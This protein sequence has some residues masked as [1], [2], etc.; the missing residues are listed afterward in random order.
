VALTGGYDFCIELGIEVVRE[1][2]HLAFKQEDR[3]P[4]NFGPFERTLTAPGGAPLTALVRVRVYDEE[5]RPADLRFTDVETLTFTFPIDIDIEL[6]D[7]PAPDL[8]HLLIP[9][10]IEVPGKLRRLPASEA[11]GEYALGVDFGEITAGD[12]VIT[13][14]APLPA[15]DGA[16]LTSAIHDAYERGTFPHQQS[17]GGFTLTAYDGSRDTSLSPPNESGAEIGA[18][19]GAGD[20]V[21]VT[22]PIHVGGEQ[23]GY[24]LSSYG[25][26]R[27]FR[28]LERS[29]DAVVLHM[30]QV[31]APGDAAHATQVTL[32]EVPGVDASVFEAA[33]HQAYLDGVIV[34]QTTMGGTL[35]LYDGTADPALVPAHPSAAEI[36]AELEVESGTTY[37][38]IQIPCHAEQSGF[39]SFGVLHIHRVVTTTP[40][41]VSVDF[42][43]APA[44][45]GRETRFEMEIGFLD[46]ILNAYTGGI[47]LAMNAIGVQSGPNPS[48]AIV[49]A[50]AS[51]FDAFSASMGDIV[52]AAPSDARFD[53]L[54][55]DE[56]AT[57]FATLS[58]PV[59]T[60]DPGENDVELSDPVGK[61]LV[62]DEILAIQMNPT[63][64]EPDAVPDNF[65]GSERLAL[66]VGLQELQRQ[67][68][69]HIAETFPD[70]ATEGRDRIE[71]ITNRTVWLTSLSVTPGS[72]QFNVSG[73]ATVEVCCWKDPDIDF[74]GPVYLN[75]TSSTEEGCMLDIQGEAGEFDTNQSSCDIVLE[76]F[77]PVVGWIVGIVIAVMIDSVGGGIAE[78]IAEEQEEV[79]S[80]L[81]PVIFGIAQVSTCLLDVL[82]RPDGLVM[83]ATVTV[84]R[85]DRSY[86]D[87][88][89]DRRLPGPGED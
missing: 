59:Y 19:L 52:Q 57:H 49:E 64:G 60:P 31:P 8:S 9:A 35:T 56:V 24:S 88:D 55:R 16:L 48:G 47:E 32:D 39:G 65:L 84:E 44:A 51:A 71:E 25:T 27:F 50:V 74:S 5:A 36:T 28:Q 69:E 75:V 40:T 13:E 83:P 87:L 21:E 61:L 67:L 2:F 86:E 72:G 81:P 42:A 20:W 18:A 1:I 4:H 23:D 76:I 46:S 66:A 14:R 82:I 73:S 33:L 41:Q 37:L 22:V 7:S 62:G 68:D 53:Q 58:Y 63:P 17:Q 12:V 29:D 38:H 3:F 15:V 77:V 30:G 79:I 78:E 43:A 11:D 80:A 85:V 26:L 6:V 45:P 70:L 34:H 54:L 89:E 10:V